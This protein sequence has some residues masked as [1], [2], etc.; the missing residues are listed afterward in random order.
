MLWLLTTVWLA[1]C[2]RLGFDELGGGVS[3]P[4]PDAPLAP[5]DGQIVVADAL[6]PDAPPDAPP[7]GPPAAPKVEVA[8]SL[9]LVTTCGAAP[10]ESEL[11]VANT[12]TAE[13]TI[14]SATATNGF[15][16][17]SA[18]DAI[19]AGDSAT[20]TIAPPM[21]VVGTD[22]GGA[23]KTGTLTLTTNAGTHTVALE[24]TVQG[25][26]ITVSVATV[27]FTATNGT[28]CPAPRT[29]TISNTGNT[30]VAI[31]QLF[32]SGVTLSGFTGGT[33]DANSS[34]SVTIQPAIC[35]A[36]STVLALDAASGSSGDNAVCVT[37][38]VN[39]T[40]NI[41]ASSTS[42]CPCS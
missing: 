4:L 25:A 40:L 15:Q 34:T 22:R 37:A 16:V 19:A 42:G 1:A 39:I 8:S 27:A 24:A 20:F 38:T 17:T 41:A 32:A 14:A 26:N 3:K 30:S 12:G 10:A 13:L 21:A 7:D 11:V 33:I 36:S 9:A 23:I 18:T 29:V 31:E 2:G 35:G 5:D 28:T 6:T